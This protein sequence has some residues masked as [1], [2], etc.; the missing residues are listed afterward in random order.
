MLLFILAVIDVPSTASPPA[1]PQRAEFGDYLSPGFLSPPPGVRPVNRIRP[2]RIK[3]A[4]PS[5]AWRYHDGK[6]ELVAFSTPIQHIVVIYMENR[7]PENLFGGYF[8]ILNPNTGHFF[9]VD[10]DLSNP[11]NPPT[12]PLPEHPLTYPSNPGHSHENFATEAAGTWDNH[13]GYW[14]I[15]SPDVAN[16]ISLI[17]YWA[18]ANHVLQSNEGPSFEAHQYA[19]AGQS[20]GLNSAIAPEGMVNNPNHGGGD[21]PGNGSCFNATSVPLPSVEVVNMFSPYPT[22]TGSPATAPCQD[23]QTITDVLSSATLPVPLPTYAIW[24]YVAASPGS[25]WAAPMAVQHLY[26]GYTSITATP[27]TQPFAVDPDAENWML[28]LES[29][30]VPTPNPVRPIAE[31]T[32]LTPCIN[33]SDHPNQNNGGT[34]G[35]D[36]GPQW[37]AYVLNVIGN[38]AYWNTTAVIVTWDDWGGFY[39]NY[40]PTPWP[41]H[42]TP[43]PYPT[44]LGNPSDPNE[45]GFRVPLLM[46]SPYVK[47]RGYVATERMSQGAILNFIETTFGL[48]PNALGADDFTNK[49][50]DLTD[51]L[52]ESAS[53]LPYT[54]VP[55][56][57]TPDN[58]DV[59]PQTPPGTLAALRDR[60]R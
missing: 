45:W 13:A 29:S 47:S 18:Y 19:I 37:L 1:P 7:T 35:Y 16:Y 46:I 4:H 21:L 26:D 56:L 25:I 49:T 28:N 36:D 51:M 58:S 39:D 33:E 34:S 38:S 40:S 8:G 9:G 20:G 11:A 52:N 44:P 54:A 50:N 43:N 30:S 32:F 53:P 48:T 55:S 59:C 5:Y 17:E 60:V 15:A 42:M 14:Y 6:R 2:S 3:G 27:A 57:F 24:Q 10:L 12:S 23:Y 22:P 31:L 41:F